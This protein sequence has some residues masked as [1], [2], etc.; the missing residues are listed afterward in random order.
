M[1][2][3]KSRRFYI[4]SLFGQLHVRETRPNKEDSKPKRPVICFHQSPL[5]GAQYKIFQNE[6]GRDRI[7]Y[8]PDTP[9]FGG[10]DIPDD[11]V[12]ISHYAESM[13]PLLEKLS[14]E[15]TFDSFD[16]LGGHTGSV[17]ALEIALNKPN[18]IN[19]I[20]LP[21]I[22]FFS[23]EERKEI[24]SKFVNVPK[25]FSDPKFVTRIYSDTVLNSTT[26]ISEDRKLEL[27]A[28]RLRSGLTAWYA[29]NAVTSYNSLEALK[30]TSHDVLI[31][32]LEDM[33][34]DNSIKASKFLKNCVVKDLRHISHSDAWDINYKELVNEIKIFLD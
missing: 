27:F 24:K 6:L 13:L 14:K 22:A 31:I 15:T 34:L 21:S 1:V 3:N 12:T 33:L 10:S 5:S 7:V 17:I 29:P 2:K 20:I 28:E 11:E 9:G 25:Y 18:L 4:D 32:L 8:C 16:I 30:K 23:E 26:P 19:K